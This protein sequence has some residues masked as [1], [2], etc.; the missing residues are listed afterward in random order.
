M[1][2]IPRLWLVPSGKLSQNYGL[3]HMTGKTHWPFSV[4]MLVIAR[5]YIFHSYPIINH[6]K[7]PLNHL[8]I[9]LNHYKFLLNHNEIPLNHYKIPLKPH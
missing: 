2:T 6:H 4:A 3:N 8:K 5:R 1:F 9:P 7:I